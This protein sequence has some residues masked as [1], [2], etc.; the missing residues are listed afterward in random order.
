MRPIRK[1]PKD[2]SRRAST[3]ATEPVPAPCPSG[4]SVRLD[5]K[6]LSLVASASR[7][8]A[9]IMASVRLYFSACQACG[10]SNP[11]DVLAVIPLVYYAAEIL[12]LIGPLLFSFFSAARAA[13][14]NKN[15]SDR[16]TRW[17]TSDKA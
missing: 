9:N 2:A 4:S 11:V 15:R 12:R 17:G 10:D 1:I 7:I 13:K 3:R 16:P 8:A 6:R 5:G 14:S